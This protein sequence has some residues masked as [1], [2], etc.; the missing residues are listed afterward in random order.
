[1]GSGVRG[2]FVWL[3]SVTRLL[4]GP[5]GKEGLR[6]TADTES[7]CDIRYRGRGAQTGGVHVSAGM[8]RPRYGIERLSGSLTGP[9]HVGA[10]VAPHRLHPTGI[11]LICTCL[12]REEPYIMDTLRCRRRH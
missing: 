10:A 1:M 11:D 8:L 7:V 12:R 5:V 3:S 2:Q 6:M 4:C 9:D